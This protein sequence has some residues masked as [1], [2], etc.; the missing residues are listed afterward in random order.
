[1]VY[2]WAIIWVLYFDLSSSNQSWISKNR[3]WVQLI[4]KKI[5]KIW[6]IVNLNLNGKILK[7]GIPMEVVGVQASDIFRR[8]VC[9]PKQ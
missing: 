2:H 5:S 7:H 3:I 9:I 1:M 8:T 6:K 4:Y